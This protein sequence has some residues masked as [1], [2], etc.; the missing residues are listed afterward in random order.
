MDIGIQSKRCF[1]CKEIKPLPEFYSHPSMADGHL[2]KCKECA[3]YD[4]RKHRAA[5]IERIRNY[6]RNRPN[7]AERNLSFLKASKRRRASSEEYRRRANER[8]RRWAKA[9]AHKKRATVNVRRA[10]LSGKMKRQP[11][12]VCGTELLVQAHHEDYSKPLDVRWLCVKHHA[13]RHRE[14][15][16][17]IRKAA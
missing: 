3:I 15:N 7:A 9:N 14:I 1:K 8:A 17:E 10:I 16:R 6:D 12:E 11:C 4:A 13:E 2:N 5:N